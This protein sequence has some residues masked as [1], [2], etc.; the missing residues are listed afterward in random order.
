LSR[1]QIQELMALRRV[2]LPKMGQLLKDRHRISRAL[3]DS[4]VPCPAPFS[5]LLS[6]LCPLLAVCLCLPSAGQCMVPFTSLLSG[7][8]SALCLCLPFVGSLHASLHF[9][10][11]LAH[12]PALCLCLPSVGFLH[13]SLCFP[14][15]WLTPLPSV[16][17][18]HGLL[19]LPFPGLPCALCLLL[20]LCWLTACPLPLLPF[21]P[22]HLLLAPRLA[23]HCMLLIAAVLPAFA[24]PPHHLCALSVCLVVVLLPA[25]AC[26]LQSCACFCLSSGCA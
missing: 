26:L 10:S 7:L 8:P 21:R 22:P 3:Q 5:G 2:F 14:L 6:A 20:A 1:Q 16:G 11:C 17:S 9:P 23:L 18:L 24:C 15:F 4:Q 12:P 19:H 13:V 25:F